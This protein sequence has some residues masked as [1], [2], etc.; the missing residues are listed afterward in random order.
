[1][2]TETNLK[3]NIFLLNAKSR[4][5]IDKFHLPKIKKKLFMQRNKGK[6]NASKKCFHEWAMH[7]CPSKRP[8]L[9]KTKMN[10]KNKNYLNIS[11]LKNKLIP[12][13]K[14]LIKNKC[15]NQLFILTK[16]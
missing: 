14:T 3:Q 7:A 11:N 13:F 4:K 1:M 12:F 2:L 16:Y 15:R 6:I 5:E 9:Q 10:S 8:K